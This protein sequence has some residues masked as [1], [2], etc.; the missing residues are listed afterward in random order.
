MNYYQHHIGDYRRD[1]AH[2]S[3]L[4]HGVYR[5][6]LDTYYLSEK[7]FDAELSDICRKLSA[8]SPDEKAAVETVLNE[9]FA[10]TEQGWT[11]KRCQCEIEAYR[12]KAEHARVN[13]MKGGRPRKLENQQE[14]EEKPTGFLE[15]PTGKLTINHKPLTNNHISI[16]QEEDADP[17]AGLPA[18]GERKVFVKPTVHEV[19]S[20]AVQC[21]MQISDGTYMWD[22]WES[23]GWMRN[24]VKLKN[25]KAAFRTWKHQGWL[26]SQ[27]LVVE[28][29]KL[30][31]RNAL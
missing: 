19:E 27:K 18:D 13:G 26:P 1:T 17:S 31:W 7:P 20:Y 23:N 29:P 30:D 8:R 14:T 11:H 6:L 28:K 9:F 5:Q 21:G 4:E 24:K 2:L 3:L 16:E 15:K 10:L 12:L 22:N 25:W